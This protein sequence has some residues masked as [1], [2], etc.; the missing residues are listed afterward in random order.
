MSSQWEIERFYHTVVNCTDL[1]RSIAFYKKLGFRVLHDRRDAVWP[2]F[3]ATN[4]AMP[5]A[6]GRGAL[7]VLE[8][9]PD[10]PIVDLVE[11]TEPRFAPHTG[12]E[13]IRQ[14]LAFRTRNVAE[15]YRTL[16]AAGIEFTNE[17]IGPDESL[18]LKGVCCCL[19]PDGNVVELIEYAAGQRHSRTDD[20]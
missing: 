9:D 3:V 2:D 6:Q 17:L 5:R 10:G 8:S 15:A 13:R 12:P 4:F 16:T 11:W 7:L 18:G 14:I 1:D 20:L 19:D